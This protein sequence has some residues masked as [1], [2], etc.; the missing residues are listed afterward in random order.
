MAFEGFPRDTLHTPTPD[1]LFGPVL[2]D[3]QDL[4]ELKVT[5]RGIWLLHH[6]RQGPRTVVA[7]RVPG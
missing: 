5:L 4:A 1:P 2:E 3:I 7:G 6:R